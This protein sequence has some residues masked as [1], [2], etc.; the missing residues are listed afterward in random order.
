ML[1]GLGVWARSLTFSITRQTNEDDDGFQLS[2]FQLLTSFEVP[3]AVS[4]EGQVVE[5]RCPRYDGNNWSCDGCG[6]GYDCDPGFEWYTY[7]NYDGVACD[8]CPDCFGTIESP[9][10]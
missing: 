5:K 1:K 3:M 2:R 9:T 7:V 8:Y 6:N 4:P 10:V